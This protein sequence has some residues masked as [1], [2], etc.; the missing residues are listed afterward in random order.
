[1]GLLITFGRL[2]VAADAQLNCETFP[3]VIVISMPGAGRI[4]LT[5]FGSSLKNY[6]ECFFSGGGLTS[7]II[8][9]IELFFEVMREFRLE[10]LLFLN[11]CVCSEC[12]S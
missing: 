11:L 8:G 10:C 6:S 7:K 4:G 3:I 9:L 12:I 2:A 5:L 1:L